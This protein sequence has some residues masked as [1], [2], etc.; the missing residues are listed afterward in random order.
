[1]KLRAGKADVFGKLEIDQHVPEQGC[2]CDQQNIDP[3]IARSFDQE[4][5]P[6]HGQQLDQDIL[7][8]C[9]K[10]ILQPDVD[11]A[12]VQEVCKQIRIIEQQ[13][14]RGIP[15]Q[16]D[17]DRIDRGAENRQQEAGRHDLPEG[18][19]QELLLIA[20]I[21]GLAAAVRIDPEQRQRN[22]DVPGGADKA[23]DAKPLRA[24]H[25]GEVRSSHDR[26]KEDDDLICKIVDVVF[27]DSAHHYP[28]F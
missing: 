26:R 14:P 16:K 15:V 4:K 19:R 13:E 2:A 17:E 24:D 10:H 28:R 6:S 20:H 21:G 5:D 27:A 25:S 3:E 23:V 22:D 11:P 1:M 12:A 7:Y 18:L 8:H 9:R